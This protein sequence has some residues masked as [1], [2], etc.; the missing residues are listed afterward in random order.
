MTKANK[1][2]S[3]VTQAF[4]SPLS[5]ISKPTVLLWLL[6][7]VYILFFCT[8]SLQR[9][10]TFNTFAAD[11]SFIDQ[12]MWNTLQGRFLERTLDDRQVPRVAEH[13]EPIIIPIALV[14]YVWDD[15]RAIL[16]IQTIALA[17]G[18]L[19]VYWIAREQI[20]NIKWQPADGKS[21]WLP[22]AFVVVYLIFPA[23]QA[24][25]V[26]DF[27]ADPFVVTP[28]LFAFWYA[29][30]GRY[31]VMWGWAILAMLVKENLPTLTF[32]LG[33]YL[34]FSSG[35]RESGNRESGNQGSPY[36]GSPIPDSLGPRFPDSLIPR[37]PDSLLTERRGHGLAMMVVSLIW[38]YVATFLIVAPL[39]SEV[40]GTNG[41]IYLSN[42]YTNLG[43]GSGSLLE[44]LRAVLTLLREPE[45]L[46][47]L[48][49]LFASVGWLALLAPEFLLLGLPV[50]VANTF[51]N[52]P[53]QYSGEQ[54]YSA[55]LAPV[56]IIAAI[57]GFRRLSDLAS[58]RF[59]ARRLGRYV[60]AL[61]IVWLLVWSLG[62][63]YLRGWTPLARGFDWP[64]HT[65]HHRL[66]NHFI[67]QIPPEAPVSTT[68]PLHPHLAH[69]EKI[70]IFPT[71]ADAD[72]VLLDISGRTDAHPNDVR[73]NFDVLVEGGEFEIVDAADGYV[74]LR[75]GQGA[76]SE[77]Q[78]LPDAF[79]DFARVRDVQ[80]QYPTLVEFDGRLRFLGYDV[81]DDPKWQQTHLRLYW[82][83]LAPLSDNPT[84]WPIFFSEDG[85]IIEDSS[86]RPMVVPLWYP[87]SQWQ[88]DE[89][90]IIETIPWD[91]GPRFNVGL[92]V[93]QGTDGERKE[94]DAAASFRD[95]DRRL[96]ITK[97]G[98]DVT[99]FHGDTWT[100]IGAFARKDR[101][102]SPVKDNPDLL[103]LGVSFA[104]GIRL[105]KYQI[106]NIKSQIPN[107]KSQISITLEWQPTGPISRDYTAFVHLVASDGTIVSQ[108][109]TQPTWVVSW[110][111]SHWTPEQPV[112]DNH[113]LLI[114]PDLSPDH[115][116]VQ[117]GLYYWET[118][119]RLPVLDE[120]MQPIKDHVIL[121]EIQIEP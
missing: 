31:W 25:N 113:R 38:F 3:S 28:L 50:L 71:I 75:R 6:I 45:R 47:Y 13:L 102:L 16:I 51:S 100:Q 107:T 5:V 52:F 64:H 35:V 20:S 36:P 62:Y 32:M 80:P 70:Y 110:P 104:E 115:Y 59:Q 30:Q 66:L 8:Y 7:L 74:L 39:A 109:D 112:L 11:L 86:Q 24:A 19:P 117:A 34:F 68:P 89:I 14:F 12:P 120:T 49:G 26:A 57:Y 91:L 84:P 44:R 65:D 27:H 69:R 42:R 55:P 23:L 58:Q 37:L 98:P 116:Q 82:Q 17:L 61:L 96:P 88:P 105:N 90:I 53:G 63:H 54:H 106:S 1:I 114:P 76:E 79:Y 81:V 56:F 94:T 99:L 33:L 87:P 73:R 10:A 72:Y 78:T 101:D 29:M 41:P 60:P 93:L 18:A 2:F 21:Q 92:A 4:S 67:D 83:S 15:V 77:K 119:E 9:H 22:L 97:A 111:T 85:D 40:Y 95:P 118:L 48:A 108:F 46:I 103:P 43:D 121:G